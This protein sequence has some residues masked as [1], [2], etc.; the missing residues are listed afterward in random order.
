VDCLGDNSAIL[1]LERLL[2]DRHSCRAFSPTELPRE[3]IERI[4][5]AAQ[6]TAS[7]CNIQPWQVK[8]LSGVALARLR[9]AM[10]ERAASGAPP[11]SDIPPIERY[12]G[13]H[14]ERRRDC[15]WSL[16]HSVGVQKGDRV[17]SHNQALENFRFFGAPHVALVTT[18]ASLG[19]RGIADCGGYVMSFMLAAHALDVATVA[20]A[21]IAHRADVIH[22]ELSLP[23]HQIVICAISFGLSDRAH[24]ANSFRMSR[25]PIDQVVEFISQ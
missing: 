25:A 9:K 3:T 22:E 20:Q 18:D 1:V 19:T 11:V 13:I 14:Q 6:R 2:N 12:T 4:V 17:A 23:S 8:I 16:Y 21:S 7:D 15:G 5:T 10:Y 24:P